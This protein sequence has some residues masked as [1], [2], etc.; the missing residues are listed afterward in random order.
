MLASGCDKSWHW[1]VLRIIACI[2]LYITTDIALHVANSNRKNS[3]KNRIPLHTLA[4]SRSLWWS[5]HCWPQ[6]PPLSTTKKFLVA[7]LSNFCFFNSD[8]ILNFQSYLLILKNLLI[9]ILIQLILDWI[10]VCNRRTTLPYFV[11]T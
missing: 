6:G 8:C 4:T 2:N 3:I 11:L 9:Q 1:L 10:L 5:Y 7:A